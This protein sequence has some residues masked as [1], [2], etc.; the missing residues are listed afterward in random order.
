MA[1]RNARRLHRRVDHLTVTCSKPLLHVK[2]VAI[3]VAVKEPRR[4]DSCVV[5]TAEKADCRDGVE[6][7]EKMVQ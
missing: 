1:S 7:P 5:A 3:A 2:L 6:P 4:S